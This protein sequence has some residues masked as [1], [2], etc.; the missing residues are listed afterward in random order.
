[1]LHPAVLDVA[2]LCVLFVAFLVPGV[3]LFAKQD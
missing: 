3:R 1:M 2:V